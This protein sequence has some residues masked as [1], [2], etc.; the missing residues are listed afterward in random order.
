MPY[1]LKLNMGI[2]SKLKAADLNDST[3]GTISFAVD[4]N[5]IFIDSLNKEK[6]RERI[7]LYA[8]Y[9]YGLKQEDGSL[10]DANKF[11]VNNDPVGTGSFSLNRRSDSTVGDYSFCEGN[12]NISAGK[13]SHAG[14]E[15]TIVNGAFSFGFG[16]GIKLP[17]INTCAFGKYNKS[18]SSILFAIGSGTDDANR[19]N[20]LELKSLSNGKC[21][22]SVDRLNTTTI[23]A[24]N[25][26]LSGQAHIKGDL[27]IYGD[28]NL[29]EN[30]NINLDTGNIT[31]EDGVINTNRLS[32]GYVNVS[33]NLTVKNLPVATES[34]VTTYTSNFVTESEV[35]NI[36]ETNTTITDNIQ[37]QIDAY[38]PFIESS[39]EPGDK[40]KIWIDTSTTIPTMK[41][42]ST[43]KNAWTKLG[44]YWG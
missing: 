17:Y 41:Y 28:I 38:V 1:Q 13:C 22:L 27:K 7:P 3:I 14:G 33:G 8:D 40:K 30:C 34:F 6:Q 36:I 12:N 9:A 5:K 42:Y 11:M 4:T 24:A 16:E 25:L 10:L 43:S 15:N 20:G 37:S 23:S 35:N 19:T 39:T 31:V 32:A 18:D 2:E 29:D 26:S 44:A 21:S